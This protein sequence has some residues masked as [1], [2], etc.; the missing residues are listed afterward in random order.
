MVGDG[1]FSDGCELV[2]LAPHAEIERSTSIVG[3][4]T[5]KTCGAISLKNQKRN[6]LTVLLPEWTVAPENLA[7]V[8]RSLYNQETIEWE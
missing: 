8:F 2:G 4:A 1:S 6:F 5:G 3:E 7:C